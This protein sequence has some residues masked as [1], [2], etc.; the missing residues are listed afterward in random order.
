ME[1]E[2]CS[3]CGANL[4]M[5]GLRHR[6]IPKSGAAVEG[7]GVTVTGTAGTHEVRES[8]VVRR[9]Y[10]GPPPDATKREFRKPLAK[11]ADKTL[12]ATK[13]WEAAG[14]SRRTWYRQQARQKESKT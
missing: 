3:E 12:M 7:G 8:P 10:N 9:R 4:A 1:I 2:R 5:V 6:C 11:D 13:P 14:I